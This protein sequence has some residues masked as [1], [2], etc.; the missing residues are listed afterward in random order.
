MTKSKY[1][2]SFITEELCRLID[3]VYITNL[4]EYLEENNL[5]NEL[6]TIE[7]IVPILDSCIMELMLHEENM[8]KF[9][10]IG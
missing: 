8:S 7:E 4:T 9:S 1:I 5:E 3:D 6:T 2:Y 10:E